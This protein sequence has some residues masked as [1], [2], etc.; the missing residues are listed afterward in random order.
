MAVEIPIEG[1]L[2]E[3]GRDRVN[4]RL[5]TIVPFIVMK[6]MALRDRLK[7]KDAYDILYAVEN[8]PGGLDALVE[9]FR[10]VLDHGL[11]RE[12]LENIAASFSSEKDVGPTF[13]ADFDEIDDAEDR[14][15]RQ[16]D[17]YE[18]MDYLLAKLGIR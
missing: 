2:P 10:K 17:A 11:V 6:S 5:P 12:C 1:D 9:E 16:R 14:A 7:E 8:F 13:V 15:L 18:R 4:V 3:G